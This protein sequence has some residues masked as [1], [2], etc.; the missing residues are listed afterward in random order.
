MTTRNQTEQQAIQSILQPSSSRAT[1]IWPP[2]GSTPINEFTTVEYISCAFPTLFP[3]GSAE[4]LAPRHHSVTIG[5]YF[6]HLML[7]NDQRFT[8]HPRF[9]YFA[10]NTEM[11]HR[12]LQTGRVYVRQNP[13]DGHIS[14]DELREM[15]T[16]NEAMRLS[17]TS[18]AVF[19]EHVNSG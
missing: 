15:S 1:T 3:T 2:T 14:I 19:V 4:L 10:L 11:R 13:Q 5:N 18:E 7:Y 17:N 12:A 16:G 8:K 9:R 6:K